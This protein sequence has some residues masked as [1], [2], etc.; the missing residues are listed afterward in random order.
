[1]TDPAPGV[2][3]ALRSLLSRHSLGGK[4][5][6]E[7]GPDDA[8]LRLMAEA[9]LHAPDHA[10]LVPF[11]FKVVR[12]AARERMAGLFERAALAAGK[13]AGEAR[14]DAGRALRPPVTVAVL[15]RID[16]GH[17]VVPAHEQWAAVGGAITNFLNAA[18]ALGFAGKML[19]GNKARQPAIQAAFC[20]AGQTLVGWISL[21]TP[22]QPPSAGRAKAGVEQVVSE[23]S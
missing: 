1:M 13:D 16:A 5:L 7:P 21:G 6:V 17:P 10:G 22:A 19:S 18:H 23:W 3:L 12:G 9:A 15:A 20:D 4:H 2:P 11:R 8:A 14:I